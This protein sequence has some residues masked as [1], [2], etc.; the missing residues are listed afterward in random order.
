MLGRRPCWSWL[1]E[2]LRLQSLVE[3]SPDTH[4]D[5]LLEMTVSRYSCVVKDNCKTH[6]NKP[7]TGSIATAADGCSLSYIF[8]GLVVGLVC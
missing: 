4:D 3:L 8:L 2:G 1:P 6:D 7:T 5:F